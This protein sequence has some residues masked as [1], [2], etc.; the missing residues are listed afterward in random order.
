MAGFLKIE[1]HS[2]P[3]ISFRGGQLILFSQSV[4]L[5]IPGLSGGLVWNRPVSLLV[6]TADGQEKVLSIQDTTRQ[7]LWILLGA[8]LFVGIISLIEKN[9]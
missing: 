5:Q 8:T 7:V 6:V 9:R 3:P 4:R 1:N 2:A